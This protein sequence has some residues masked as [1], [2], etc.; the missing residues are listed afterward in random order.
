[1][2]SST[3]FTK[4]KVFCPC[5]LCGEH[6]HN[7]GPLGKGERVLE[8]VNW[9]T[10]EQTTEVLQPVAVDDLRRHLRIDGH[11]DDAELQQMI[12]AATQ[13]CKSGVPGGLSLINRTVDLVLDVFPSSSDR[14]ELP[15][16]PFQ[17]VTSIT[18]FDGSNS[19][20]TLSSSDYQTF[21]P[22]EGPGWL[23]PAIDKTWPSTKLRDDAVTVKYV[24]GYGSTPASVPPSMRHAIRLL[25]GHFYENREAFVIGTISK[26]L[27]FSV[28]ALLGS[29]GYGYYG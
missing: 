23:K 26:E 20:T 4:S 28:S 7:I 16:P 2:N 10:V 14:L 17:S 15:F 18:Y 29:N 21:A 9:Y 13:Y 1:M 27:E 19:S 11:S 12:N 5:G 8:G 3:L 22:T 24:C 25:S 6:T